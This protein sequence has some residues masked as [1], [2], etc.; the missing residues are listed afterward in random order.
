ML[1]VSADIF[2]YGSIRAT[3]LTM[4]L[5]VAIT[6]LVF[7]FGL[8]GSAGA[9]SL[10]QNLSQCSGNNDELVIQGCTGLLKSSRLSRQNRAVAYIARG[11]AY[12]RRDELDLAI[13]DF[14]KAIR[15]NPRSLVAYYNR[16]NAYFTKENF[17]QAIVDFSRA[18]S[19][20]PDHVLSYNNRGNAYLAKG[21][22]DRAIA[23]FDKALEIDPNNTQAASNRALAYTKSGDVGGVI[24]NFGAVV[25]LFFRSLFG[26]N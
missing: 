7:G 20:Q 1:A 25:R 6:T 8:A 24:R 14:T 3:I 2:T 13:D 10:Q 21:E 16:G 18:I 26:K 15:R 19:L 9:Q 4:K 23:E 22:I 5:L 17:D 12:A 11:S